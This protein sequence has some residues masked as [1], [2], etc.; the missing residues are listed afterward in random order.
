MSFKDKY[1][2]FAA[3]EGHIRRARAERSLMIA[4]ALSNGI[5]AVISGA[6]RLAAAAGSGLA[7]EHD[8]SAIEAD[9]FLKRAVPKY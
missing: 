9:S 4:T 8:R 2:D 1:P 6:K 7:K 3:V 5:M